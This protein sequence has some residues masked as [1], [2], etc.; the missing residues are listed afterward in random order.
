MKQQMLEHIICPR[1]QAPNLTAEQ[2]CFACGRQLGKFARP[3]ERPPSLPWVLWFGIAIALAALGVLVASASQLLASYRLEAG[4]PKAHMLF[5]A[6]LLLAVGQVALYR[7]RR[8]DRRWWELKRTPEMP[9]TQVSSRD[10]TWVR[11]A[12]QC[13]APLE[14]PY[15]PDEKCVYYHLVVKEQEQ[16][17][18]GGWRTTQNERNS[19]DFTVVADSGAVYVPSGG[20][21]F[22]APLFVDTCPAP[23][24]RAKV[25]AVGLNTP[26]T[27]CGRVEEE[28]GPRLLVRLSETVPLIATWR[29]PSDYLAELAKRGRRTQWLGWTVS[30]LAAAT[31]IATLARG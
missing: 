16:T 1:C 6:A 13:E 10:A 2:V 7:A 4:V 30:F 12:V 8:E 18:K 26:L 23:G 5:A 15:A 29:F 19:V 17:E 20:V 31:L 9:L 11:G 21:H 22:E 27:V 14:L 25:W 3:R 24:V 28:G